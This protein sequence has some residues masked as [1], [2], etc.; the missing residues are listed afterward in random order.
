MT[1]EAFTI[2]AG[3]PAVESVSAVCHPLGV[4]LL[5]G[6]CERAGALELSAGNSAAEA[7]ARCRHCG[8]K[9][10]VVI[11]PAAPPEGELEGDAEP[12]CPKCQTPVGQRRACPTCGLAAERMA[13]FA[14]ARDVASP[15][16]E[17]CWQAALDAWTEQARHDAFV[18]AAAGAGAFAF[19]AG[20]YQEATRAR[21]DDPIAPRQLARVRRTAE[22]AMLASAQVRHVEQKPYRSATAVLVLLVVALVAGGVYAT[23]LRNTRGVAGAEV[24]PRPVAPAPRGPR[25]APSGLPGPRPR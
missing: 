18:Q 1:R 25:P 15:A 3:R 8:A 9:E 24:A 13:T 6:A 19:A 12:R 2:G 11:A 21:P 17:A 7:W 20:K 22:A 16:L 4:K 5:C 10:R 23:F 14:A